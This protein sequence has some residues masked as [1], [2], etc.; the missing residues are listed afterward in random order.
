MLPPTVIYKRT[1]DRSICG[2]KE[3]NASVISYQK[4]AW[5]DERSM[6]KWISDIWI[7]YTKN[8]PSLLFLDS[9]TAHLTDKAKDAVQRSN[10]TVIVIPGGWTSI[11]NP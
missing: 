9:F 3:S 7:K 1:T 10:S 2:V 4:K 6:L 11:L 8:K 5:M